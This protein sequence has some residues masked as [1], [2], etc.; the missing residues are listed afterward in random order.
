MSVLPRPPV[1]SQPPVTP[2]GDD[3]SGIECTTVILW[4]VQMAEV[5]P[6][7][8]MTEG[9]RAKVALGQDINLYCHPSHVTL[10]RFDLPDRYGKN[11]LPRSAACTW[12]HTNSSSTDNTSDKTIAIR[13]PA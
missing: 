13:V 6:G 3:D 11:A 7:F 9:R 4:N 5:P 1:Y 8:V 10:K 2:Q 12:G